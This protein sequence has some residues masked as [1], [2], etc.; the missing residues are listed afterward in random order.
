MANEEEKGGGGSVFDG[1][2]ENN[3]KQRPSL[4]YN[5]GVYVLLYNRIKNDLMN[6]NSYGD[7]TAFDTQINDKIRKGLSGSP[8]EV[9]T[10]LSKYKLD[11]IIK[12]YEHILFVFNFNVSARLGH[13]FLEVLLPS[14]RFAGLWLLALQQDDITYQHPHILNVHLFHL[15]PQ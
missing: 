15:L 7:P 3:T 4:Y 10:F 13:A 12:I 5:M 2:V 6:N 14:L 9:R 8:D 11:N 1:L